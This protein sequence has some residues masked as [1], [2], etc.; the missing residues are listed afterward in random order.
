MNIPVEKSFLLVRCTGV[1][2]N[3]WARDSLCYNELC[4]L[5]MM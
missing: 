2:N 1:L 5:A 4:M 3:V